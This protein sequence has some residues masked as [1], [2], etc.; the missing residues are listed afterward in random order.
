[1]SSF[2]LYLPQDAICVAAV[3]GYIDIYKLISAA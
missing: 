1:M 2:N 3:D